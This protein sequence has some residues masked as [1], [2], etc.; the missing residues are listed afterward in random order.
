MKYLKFVFY[1]SI[2][3]SCFLYRHCPSQASAISIFNFT[4]TDDYHDHNAA[5]DTARFFR[6]I[7]PLD[8][9]SRSGKSHEL[10]YPGKSDYLRQPLFY[11]RRRILVRHGA[12]CRRPARSQH[13][14]LSKSFRADLTVSFAGFAGAHLG[15]PADYPL[16]RL[17]FPQIQS[18]ELALIILVVGALIPLPLVLSRIIVEKEWDGIIQPHEGIIIDYCFFIVFYTIAA[19]T[20]EHSPLVFRYVRHFNYRRLDCLY[21][22]LRRQENWA[23]F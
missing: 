18:P 14:A 8:R 9:T 21:Y 16:D 3:C 20:R 4:G 5:E 15:R 7:R 19:R 12:G 13:V 1:R 23:P 22:L 10:H 17:G 6:R 2:F 11:P